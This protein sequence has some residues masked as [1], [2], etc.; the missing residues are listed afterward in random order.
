MGLIDKKGLEEVRSMLL[1]YMVECEKGVLFFA[2]DIGISPNTL[3]RVIYRKEVSF[4]TVAKVV[5]YLKR[6]NN[7]YSSIREGEA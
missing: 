3:K 6:K 1:D 2:K 5:N 7:L 4:K